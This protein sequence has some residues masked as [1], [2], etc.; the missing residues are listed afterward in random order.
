MSLDAIE[1]KMKTCSLEELGAVSS[2]GFGLNEIGSETVHE[3]G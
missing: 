3:L 1:M 2:I